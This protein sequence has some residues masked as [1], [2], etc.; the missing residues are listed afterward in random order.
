MAKYNFTPLIE[1]LALNP[2]N[3][4][5]NEFETIHHPQRMGNPLDIA[6]GG[7]ALGTA[8][9]AAYKCVSTGYHL[10]S[11]LGHYLGPAYSD[12]PLRAKVRTIRQTRTFATRQVEI[13]QKRDNG[14]ERICLIAMADFQV[15]E[16][17]TLLEFSKPPLESFPHH[18]GLPTQKE[19]F[20]KL[21]DDGKISQQ[22]LDAHSKTF[23]LMEAH[24]DQRPCPDSV[25]AQNLF[26][27]AKTLP[28]TQD[29]LPVTSRTTG[30]WFRCREKL[31]GEAEHL[32]NLSFLVD[33]AIS[34]LPLSLNRMWFDDVGAVSSLDFALRIFK[35]GDEVD[36]S[37]WHKREIS[38]SVASEGRSFGESWV[39]DEQGRA[40]ASMSQQSI[41]RPPPGGGKKRVKVKL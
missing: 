17:A 23:S 20:Q 13:S 6:Y 40:V 39:W 38:V 36:L 12:R 25:F 31:N 34:F 7:Y 14:E 10:Y 8:C 2:T 19:V 28:T 16:P 27:M 24:F 9:R 22:L 41:L 18:N 32:T 4:D 1:Q 11:M 21:L 5:N 29:H 37:Q 3:S 30:D 33:G 35:A 26:G 15:S